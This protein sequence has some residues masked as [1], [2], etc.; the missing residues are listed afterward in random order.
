MRHLGRELELGREL[1]RRREE[2]ARLRQSAERAVELIDELLPA[3]LRQP[4][5][6]QPQKLA[7][8]RDANAGEEAGFGAEDADGQLFERQAAAA[9]TPQ[10]RTRRRRGSQRGLQPEL[11]NARLEHGEQGFAA[12]EIAQAALDFRNQRVGRLE[13]DPR[14]ELAGPGG[15]RLEPGLQPG[16]VQRDPKHGTVFSKSG[17]AAPPSARRAA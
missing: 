17:K 10:R 15:Q 1:R 14:R 9:S 7:E 2:L 3:A 8:R 11:G 13:R 5:A 12:A 6:R 4:L 16:K